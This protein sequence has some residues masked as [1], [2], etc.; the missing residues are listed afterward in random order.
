MHRRGLAT[1]L[2]RVPLTPLA[3]RIS[4]PSLR[5]ASSSSS[6]P[7]FLTGGS[8]TGDDRKPTDRGP[9]REVKTRKRSKDPS[10]DLCDTHYEKSR[11]KRD[12]RQPRRA[13]LT[14]LREED[15]ALKAGEGP[16]EVASSFLPWSSLVDRPSPALHDMSTTE[17]NAS[18][19]KKAFEA[20]RRDDEDSE[21]LASTWYSYNDIPVGSFLELRR[22]AHR[23][24]YSPTF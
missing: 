3:S 11:Q 14:R 8:W 2:A 23:L 13:S 20:A 15:H 17:A 24:H 1:C 21:I 4:S 19:E 22:Y 7:W 9:R 10:Y 18:L 12:T 16:K 5:Y 6:Q